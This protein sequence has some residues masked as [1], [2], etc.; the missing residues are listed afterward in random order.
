M[1]FAVDTKS[2]R[3]AVD[4]KSTRFA[5]D[6]R[7]VSAALLRYPTVPKPTTVEVS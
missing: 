7:F 6:T 2:T 3:F 4:T 1:R 5:V